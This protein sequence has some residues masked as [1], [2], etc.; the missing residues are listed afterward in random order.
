MSNVLRVAH[1]STYI[2]GGAGIAA[3]RLH[4]ALSKTNQLQK[5]NPHYE[6]IESTLYCR[7]QE[8]NDISRVSSC[9]YLYDDEHSKTAGSVDEHNK[10]VD[11]FHDYS[12]Q[13]IYEGNT[14]FDYPHPPY[15]DAQKT[16][17]KII[18]TYDIIHIHWTSSLLSIEEIAYLTQHDTPV[19]FTFMDK[20]MFAGGCHY[21]HGCTL[22]E[23]GCGDCPQLK[24]TLDDMTA[25]VFQAKKEFFN[26][27]NIALIVL[28]EQFKQLADES[29]LFHKCKKKVIYNSID[30]DAIP[31]EHNTKNTKSALRKKYK[32]PQEKII[33]LY[34][35]SYTSKIKGFDEL[36]KTM[37][38]LSNKEQYH[39]IVVGPFSSADIVLDD[40]SCSVMGSVSLDELFEFYQLT[41]I[42]VV[43]SIE[44]TL[45]NICLESLAC[46]T[47]VVGFKVGGI[48]DI[49]NDEET[50]YTVEIGD[51]QGLAKAID[52]L[53]K[54]DNDMANDISDKCRK[55]AI[56][57]FSSSV[58]AEQ[59][60]DFYHEI[61]T[62]TK[63]QPDAMHCQKPDA[64]IPQISILQASRNK[65]LYSILSKYHELT[66]DNDLLQRNIHDISNNDYYILGQLPSCKKIVAFI[67]ILITSL[68]RKR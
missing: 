27:E 13:N 31:Y 21:F 37:Q 43:P 56:E 53:A 35:A 12:W 2:Y 5:N 34:A 25:M 44:D 19:V 55:F 6:R 46:G 57:N 23:K 26:F 52:I 42:T 68:M 54:Y 38:S 66:S 33:L 62:P 32:L 47:P 1:I 41:D 45:P 63:N 18:E 40:I 48:P 67:K 29:P 4:E 16:L 20:N 14:M 39:L 59:M 15:S 49:I 61:I 8:N 60:I 64:T 10:I 50:G 58:Q 30:I 3:V 28:C 7:K 24:D 22:W 65:I 51:C 11:A 17:D 9:F 36:L